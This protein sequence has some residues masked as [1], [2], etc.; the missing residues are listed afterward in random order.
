MESKDTSIVW[1][2]NESFM[3]LRFMALYD[4]FIEWMI[5]KGSDRVELTT[6][7]SLIEK[8]KG[9][10]SKVEELSSKLTVFIDEETC[11]KQRV[12]A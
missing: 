1:S 7:I 10:K 8:G 3:V 11:L 12:S 6:L 4:D 9:D 5:R 2:L